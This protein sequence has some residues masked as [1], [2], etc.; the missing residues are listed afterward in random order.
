MKRGSRALPVIAI[1]LAVGTAGCARQAAV[2][3]PT[4]SRAAGQDTA[5]PGGA[6][7]AAAPR[8]YARVITSAAETKEGLLRVHRVDDKLFF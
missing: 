2:A 4:P 1:A 3:S 7:G 6:R 8:P 5:G